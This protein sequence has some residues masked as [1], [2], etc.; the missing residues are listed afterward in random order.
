MCL[1]VDGETVSKG[2]VRYVA[3]LTRESVVDVEGCARLPDAPLT[4]V[5]QPLELAA[6]SVRCIS[7]SSAL[8]FELDDACRSEAEEA[9]EG[10][11]PRV[12]AD[13]RLDNRVLDLRTPDSQ[14]IFR[15]QSAVG[16]LFRASLEGQGF[17]EIHTPKLV[18]GA[19]E[20]GASV[21]K[22]DYMGRPACLA[23]SPQLY[24]QARGG[25][26]V[27]GWGGRGAWARALPPPPPPFAAP[28][29]AAFRPEGRV[30]GRRRIRT[31]FAPPG[32]ARPHTLLPSY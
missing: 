23:Q 10:A 27:G 11:G 8:P 31:A 12:G 5:T 3:G 1:F 7:R 4:G 30:C 2:M 20:G 17:V 28:P 26:W 25:G 29:L 6:T 15:L 21:F 22:L 19:S 24:K 9:A 32:W 16:A 13:T 14:A 18:A